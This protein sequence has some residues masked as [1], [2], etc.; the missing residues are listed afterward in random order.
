MERT[1]ARRPGLRDAMPLARLLRLVT[2]AL[3]LGA[4][5]APA[6]HA[7]SDLELGMADDAAVLQDPNTARA[8]QTVDAWRDLGVD[9][10]RLF[11]QWQL[12]A[13]RPGSTR[14][15]RGFDASDPAARGYR[16]GAL[17][18]AV[19]IVRNAGL[20]VMMTV[21]GPG[22]L[23]ATARPSRRDRRVS[24]R[25]AL[26]G[27]FARALARRYGRDVD[28]Y[29]IWNEPNLPD[30]LRPQN[31]CRGRVCT[32]AAPHLYRRLARAAYPAI[33]QADPRAQVLLGALAPRGVAPTSANARLRP[34]P[35]LRALGCVSARLRRVRTGPCRGFR[36][37]T[38]DAI[39][40]HPHGSLRAPDVSNPNRDEAPLANLP[41]LEAV[42]DGIQRAGGLRNPL[43]RARRFDLY[44]TEYGYQT[45]PPDRVDGVSPAKQARWLQQA[46]YMAWRA[47]R[48][49]NLTQ[50]VWRDERVRGVKGGW[51]SGLLFRS[52]RAKPALRSF[53]QPFWIDRSVGRRAALLWGQVRPG[54]TH[55]VDIQRAAPGSSA[56]TTIQ[57]LP[58]DAR[59]FFTLRVAVTAR[60]DY[61]FAW[62]PDGGGPV[63]ASDRRR[64]TPR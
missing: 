15:P 9:V 26:F 1:F 18:R 42:I 17:D 49:R 32:P 3:L 21:T 34:L 54:E 35:F 50:Y 64:V 31:T 19:L 55:T 60:A 53:P 30:W 5:A 51:Q 11:A 10:V 45:R 27:R 38:A 4:L 2:V 29:I 59:G 7:A 61:R 47:P 37:A 62:V 12:I 25:P 58:T 46:A 36:P 56:W 33:H 28:R 48:V 22:P 8:I 40:Y 41:R 20:R 44:F 13:P 43:G 57:T 16:W 24:P 52:G 6:A 39:A 23:W 14:A 63:R